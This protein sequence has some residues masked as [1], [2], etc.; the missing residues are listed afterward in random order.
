M[1]N[2]ILAAVLLQ[3]PTQPARIP[4]DPLSI[5]VSAQEAEQHLIG[6]QPFVRL[7]IFPPGKFFSATVRVDVLV[8]KKGA[9]L[10]AAA[11]APS[12][13]DDE[14]RSQIFGAK[15]TPDILQEAES[16]VRSLRFVEFRR[17]GRPVAVMIQQY[18][19]VLPPELKPSRGVPVPEVKDWKSV[20]VSLL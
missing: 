13:T 8:D 2:L 19:A 18:V 12:A 20:K 3:Q 9:V 10:W 6:E 5:T 16:V 17:D 14:I 15:V 4:I 7:K 11:Q 1:L